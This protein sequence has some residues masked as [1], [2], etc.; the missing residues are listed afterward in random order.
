MRKTHVY[1][2]LLLVVLAGLAVRGLYLR[3]LMTR[4]DFS[5]PQV[6]G[7][8]HHY[9]ARALVTGDWTPPVDMPDPQIR[10]T[11]YFRP[12]GYP[13]FLAAVMCVA[14][15]GY[16]GPRVIQMLLGVVNLLLVFLVAGRWY[17]NGTGLI[18]AALAG[19]YWSLI[20]YETEFLEPV[21]LV[22]LGLGLV[23]GL[24]RWAESGRPLWLLLAGLLT[25]LFALVRPNILLFALCVPVWL[26]CRAAQGSMAA[27]RRPAGLALYATGLLALLAFPATRNAVMARDPVLISANAGVNLYIGNNPAADGIFNL[28]ASGLEY[29]G[30]CFEYPAMVRALEN[31]TGRP[32]T[33]S[34]ASRVFANRAWDF[35]RAHPARALYL[36]G[37]KALLFWGPY[38]VGHNKED[39]FEK[40]MSRVLRY[41]PINFPLV[42]ALAL[43]GLALLARERAE[44]PPQTRMATG[45]I[46][47]L[48]LAYFVSFLPFFAAAQFRIPLLPFVLIF[49]AVAIQRLAAL[50]RRREWEGLGARLCAGLVL[51]GVV[52]LN[53]TGFRP[54]LAKWLYAQGAACEQ[55]G[56]AAEAVRYY[57]EALRVDPAAADARNNLGLARARAGR[58]SEAAEQFTA[59]L[60]ADPGRVEAYANYALLLARADR[61]ADALALLERALQ[62]RPDHPILLNN[63]AWIRATRA[64]LEPAETARAVRLAARAGALTDFQDAGRLDTLA[65]AC[66]AAGQFGAAVRIQERALARAPDPSAAAAMAAR[67]AEYRA[68]RRWIEPVLTAATNRVE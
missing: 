14:G 66:A 49:A 56:R 50:A 34:A 63:A 53:P 26:W 52:S 18:A 57:E 47:L 54:S 13:Y 45:L 40:P 16:L 35:V 64:R 6:D 19:F 1:L 59:A 62:L 21:L 58:L 7:A 61:P 8:Y 48:A 12:P 68:G 38:E 42:L 22:A 31:E 46:L 15:A 36:A 24:G 51:Y 28:R 44:L 2:A 60:Q 9:W 32:L 10:S 33:Y 55:T 25:G 20:Y 65:A 30:N 4:P 3:E 67:L 23:Y 29:F 37:R 41:L 5:V 27:R 43:L 17:G 11:P 39:Q